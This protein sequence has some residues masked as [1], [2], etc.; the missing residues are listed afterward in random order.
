MNA[1]KAD[2]CNVIRYMWNQRRPPSLVRKKE[3]IMIGRLIGAAI[4][5]QAAKQTSAI[6]GTAGAAMGFLVPT[7]LRRMSIPAML[8]LA[9]GAYAFKKF[10]DKNDEQRR[11]ET[12]S[13]TLVSD[14]PVKVTDYS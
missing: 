8:A 5:S 14:K 12:L 7:V 6:G 13:N 3:I 2:N 4:G 11:A 9:G 1:S 10:S